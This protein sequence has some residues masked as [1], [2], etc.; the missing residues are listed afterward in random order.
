MSIKKLLSDIK[1]SENYFRILT[2]FIIVILAFCVFA[3]QLVFSDVVTFAKKGDQFQLCYPAFQKLGSM[4]SQGIISG[5]DSGTFNGAT[6]IFLRANIPMKYLPAMVFAYIGNFTSLYRILYM[7]LFF[8]HL[9]VALYYAQKL[10]T[11]YFGMSKWVAFLLS[12]SVLPIFLYEIWY[13]SFAFISCLVFPLLYF[14]ISSIDGLKKQVWILAPLPYVLGFTAGYITLATFLVGFILLIAIIYGFVYKDHLKKIKIILRVL[15]P[16]FFAGLIILIYYFN[17]LTY[18]KGV[19]KPTSTVLSAA[20]N[21]KFNVKDLL[22]VVL[23]S[24]SYTNVIE[25]ISIINIGV[26]WCLV[27]I[28]VIN[29]KSFQELNKQQ[30]LFMKI[31]VLINV[32]FALI[33]CGNVSPFGAWFFS[34][35][36][37]LGQMQL[38]IRYMMI[39]IPVFFIALCIC[40]QTIPDGKGNV[41]YKRLFWA[42]LIVAFVSSVIKLDF[43]N[44]ERFILEMLLSAVIVYSI[45]LYGWKS[46]KTIILWSTMI[47]I[48]G[49]RL[50]YDFNEISNNGYVIQERSIVSNEFATR[51]FDNYI[52]TLKHKDQYKFANLDKSQTVPEFVPG[53]YEWYITK[54]YNISNYLG[55]ELHLGVPKDYLNRSPW[56]LNLDW[57]YISNTR[58]D[59]LIADQASI[60]DNIELF[61]QIIDWD[62]SNFYLNSNQKIYGLKKFI[63]TYYLQS[64]DYVLD[65]NDGSLDNGYFY[66]P[67]LKN[68]NLLEFST[69][70]STYFSAKINTV[71]KTDIAFLLYPNR[72]FKYYVDDEEITPIIY[73]MQAFV[74]L[75]EG[76]HTITIKY[77]N[78]VDLVG[79][80]VL[81]SYYVIAISVF[82]ILILIRLVINRRNDFIRNRK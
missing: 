13:S 61:N 20:I 3:G 42:L 48:T 49:I 14:A 64:Q 4:L 18:I 32:V 77:D 5:V 17:V 67:Y 35:I 68:N 12:V 23:S 55:Y 40:F 11:R 36:P 39:T 33:A 29:S 19:V 51:Q 74:P 81:Y 66:S 70:K 8:C 52:D 69:D 73:D 28:T 43:L 24:F 10:G 2:S 7:F 78:K 16:A 31:G 34:L 75:D 82:I 46:S 50:F 79:N 30:L 1:K 41:I 38:P 45:Y 58:G 60:D 15:T 37:I 22:L 47:I 59:F 6:E 9:F 25:Q 21:L 26:I 72:Y 27:I 44:T 62:N 53:N 56:F 65:N 71:E 76:S 63:P 54:D 80:I 57:R